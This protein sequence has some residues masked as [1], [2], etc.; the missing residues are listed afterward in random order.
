MQS[1]WAAFFRQRS[2][3]RNPRALTT[4]ILHAGYRALGALA[5]GH[6]GKAG[7][8][9]TPV[10]HV[11]PRCEASD[12]GR[13]KAQAMIHSI[14]RRKFVTGTG[15]MIAAPLA[16]RSDLVTAAETQ[17]K[18]CLPWIPHGGYAFLFAASRLG[19]WKSHGLE[20]QVDRGYGSG[21]TCKRVALG[22]YDYGLAD[23]ATM[24]KLADDGLPLTC[25]AM[26]DHVSQLGILSLKESNITKP[27]DLEGKTLG[28]TAGSADYAL[29]PG[30]VAA[31]GIDAGKVKINI[32]GP[33]LRL[34]MLTEHQ[35]D[36]IGSVYGSD[37][38][39]F[40]ARGTPYNLMLHAKYGL[41][42]YSN[43]IITQKDRV[44]KDPAQ[45]Q[46]LVDGAMEG[47]KY[48]F[49]EPDKTT[50]IHLQMVKEYDSAST[51]RNFVKYGVLINTA[52]SLAPYLEKSGLGYMEER[53][54]A[55]T[56]DK[57]AKYIGVKATQVPAALYTNQFAGKVNL[58]PAEWKAVR[59]SVQEYAL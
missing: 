7:Y 30:F 13:G 15:G 3:Q 33:E 17:L 2:R 25:I 29:W 34:R 43:A 41:E 55:A 42:M 32:V 24:V 40:L 22:Q 16:L 52:T 36:A 23:F 50:D 45:C 12:L 48:S 5:I 6:R 38:P 39:I 54:V 19:H 58:T 20:V 31:T 49:L 1:S 44:Q 46:A 18:F 47:L 57:I 35:L 27:K 11:C 28:T 9:E 51:D 10:S 53:L 4:C 21:E 37:A 14:S 59:E 8:G 56:Q 26:V